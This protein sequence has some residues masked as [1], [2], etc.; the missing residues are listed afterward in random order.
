MNEISKIIVMFAAVWGR[1]WSCESGKGAL[2]SPTWNLLPASFPATADSKDIRFWHFP[3]V[4]SVS[5]SPPDHPK[6]NNPTGG[7]YDK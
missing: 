4:V 5:L 3:W 1:L 7:G 6:N 2:P